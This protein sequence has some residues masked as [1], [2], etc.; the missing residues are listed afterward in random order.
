MK[1]VMIATPCNDGKVCLEY[2]LSLVDSIK[3]CGANDIELCPVFLGNE[4]L[5][6]IAR[7]DLI[8]IAH[9]AEVDM[10]WIDADM[11]WNPSWILELIN[12]NEDVVGGTARKKTDLEETFAV[13]VRDFTLHPNGLIKCEGMGT[14]FLKM[15]KKAVNSI[16]SSSDV[17]THH[18]KECRNVF[19]CIVID[20]DFYSEDIVLCKK[21][22]SLGF[23]IWLDPKM[24]CGHIGK[25]NYIGDLNQFIERIK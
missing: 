10:V 12:R 9:D 6:Q 24:T 25:K 13:K 19:E 23:D 2:T 18:G 22:R 5:L 1:K 15:S 8:K 16:Y 4:S 7:N 20:G 3:F 17:F 11:Q 14:A 21:L